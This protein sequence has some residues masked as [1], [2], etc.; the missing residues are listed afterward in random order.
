MTPM[1]AIEKTKREKAEWSVRVARD[2]GV[3]LIPAPEGIYRVCVRD[4]T[5]KTLAV[6]DTPDE[7]VQWLT[8]AAWGVVH[9][10]AR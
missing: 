2:L 8:G 6:C 3:E 1:E 4:A 5:E 9:G 7:L 10:S